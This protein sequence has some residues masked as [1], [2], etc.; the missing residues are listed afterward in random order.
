MQPHRAS[1]CLSQR[2][3]ISRERMAEMA[4]SIHCPHTMNDTRLFSQNWPLGDSRAQLSLLAV[5]KEAQLLGLDSICLP[6]LGWGPSFLPKTLDC[7]TATAPLMALL[8]NYSSTL[9]HLVPSPVPC[10]SPRSLLPQ[11][12][13]RHDNKIT[14]RSFIAVSCFLPKPR[15]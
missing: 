2:E 8:S 13:G 5:V 3:Q 14:K 15:E 1:T 4:L 12:P 9:C 11:Q 7:C 10:A 6:H